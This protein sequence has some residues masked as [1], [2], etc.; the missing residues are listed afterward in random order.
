MDGLHIMN[1]KLTA[2]ETN[3][4][5]GFRDIGHCLDHLEVGGGCLSNNEHISLNR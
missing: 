4:N 2:M 5:N 1:A 3:M